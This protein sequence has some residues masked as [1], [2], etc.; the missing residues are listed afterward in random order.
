[1]K[2]QMRIYAKGLAFP[3]DGAYDL[4]TLEVFVSNYRIILDRLV[5]VHLGRRQV[6][7]DIKRRITYKAKIN[8]GSIEFLIN[9]IY[10]HKEIIA[11]LAP[12]TAYGLSVILPN[13]L[14]DAIVLRRTASDLIK[15]QIPVKIRISNSFNFGSTINNIGVTFDETSGSIVINDPKILWATQLTRQPIDEIMRKVDGSEVEYVDFDSDKGGVKL[16]PEDV[17]ITGSYREELDENLSIAGKLDIIAFSAHRGTVISNDTRYAVQWNENIR[18]KIKR[19]ADID[20]ILF[21]VRPI[22]DRKRLEADI[23]SSA[24]SFHILD[25]HDPQNRMFD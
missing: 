19:F 2:D 18:K 12:D 23:A 13:M 3:T 20:G 21:K 17:A 25:C 22:V 24:I 5:A 1:M 4:R 15:N 14:R 11:I 10:E 16:T 9:F 7:K 8:P 6:P